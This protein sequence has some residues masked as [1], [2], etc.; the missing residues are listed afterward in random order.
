[1]GNRKLSR[2]GLLQGIG[3][4]SLPLIGAGLGLGTTGCS[5]GEEEDDGSESGESNI[6]QSEARQLLSRYK[7]FVIVV[8]ENRSFDHY[9]GHLSLPESE[10]GKGLAGK[11]NGFKSKAQHTNLDLN[12]NKVGIHK[13]TLANGK[14]DYSLGDIDHEWEA[15]HEQFNNGRNDGFVKAHQEDLVNLNDNNEETT[16]LCWGTTTGDAANT[17]LCGKPNDPM[18]YYDDK[19]TPVYH[20]LIKEYTLC[21]NWFSS[22]MGPTW[23]NRFY[24]HSGSS[25]GRKVNKPLSGTFR[26][27]GRNGIFGLVSA[28]VRELAR[29]YPEL[30]ESER[31]RLCTDFFADVP[32]LPI[33]FPTAAGLGDGLDFIN[34]LPNYNYA[35]LYEQPRAAGVEGL[36]RLS[37]KIFGDK[38]PRGLLNSLAAWRRSPTFEKLAQQ[39]KL[40]PI[41]YIEPPYQL[42]PADDHPPHNVMMGQAFVA[43]IYKMLKESPDWEHTLMIVTYDEHGSFYDHV[44]PPRDENEENPEFKQLGFRV[45]AMLIGKGIKKGHFDHTQYDHCSILN[46]LGTRFELGYSN[47]RVEKVNPITNAIANGTGGSAGN[48]NLDPVILSEAT[49]LESAKYADGQK[50][51]VD[52]AFHGH[53]PYEAKRLYTDGVLEIFDRL[54]V[55]K[56]GA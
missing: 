48:L 26:E 16:A 19:D 52:R 44:A 17:P 28:R 56:I 40:P 34:F 45:P 37:G 23:P 18:A 6:N 9:F 8:M 46:T 25:A 24:V 15:C 39:G 2:R 54:G 3:L 36:T 31:G 42:A 22:V 49:V 7:K 53:V 27:A 38:Q 41:S 12:G 20:Q 5:K 43:S 30:P 47:R 10:G 55:A 32:L 50:G 51:I 21:D 35:H 11:V 33:M 4:S 14:S 29:E 1:M 13:P